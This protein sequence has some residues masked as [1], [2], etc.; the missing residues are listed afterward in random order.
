MNS[1]SVTSYFCVWD[2][3]KKN[4]CVHGNRR[5]PQE[6]VTDTFGELIKRRT[7]Q[8]AKFPVVLVKICLDESS[9]CRS[10]LLVT[11][12]RA[13]VSFYCVELAKYIRRHI[14]APLESSCLQSATQGRDAVCV[15][16]LRSNQSAPLSNTLFG[17]KVCCGCRELESAASGKDGHTCPVCFLLS[18][19]YLLDGQLRKSSLRSVMFRLG[20]AHFG[21]LCRFKVRLVM[22][23]LRNICWFC[24]PEGN[25]GH[26]YCCRNVRCQSTW[27][28]IGHLV[29]SRLQVR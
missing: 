22:H 11:V 6:Q 13:V 8:C 20:T 28:G 29:C 26:L 17:E 4:V 21:R 18:P 10:T 7:F 25:F 16:A 23:S 12:G 14:T 9:M 3:C 2:D 19:T 5:T 24:V 15:T 27:S 1:C